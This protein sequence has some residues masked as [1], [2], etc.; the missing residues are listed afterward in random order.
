M[1]TAETIAQLYQAGISVVPVATDGTKRPAIAWKP[2]TLERADVDQ[3]D[4]WFMRDTQHGVGMIT[5]AVSGGVEM[6]ELEGRA[7]HHLPELAQLAEASGLADLWQ[8]I[9]TGWLELSPSGGV[10]WFYRLDGMA[11]PGNTKLAAA[12]D[13]T[14]LAETRGE[15]GFVVLAPTG[16]TA[17]PTGKPWARLA[18]GPT[19]IPTLT[20][21]ERD[22]LHALVRTLDET[23]DPVAPAPAGPVADLWKTYRHQDGD[24]TPGDD[25]EQRTDWAEILTP[26]GWTLIHQRGQ[27][28]YWCRPGKKHGISASTGKASDRDRL[29]VFT[30]STEFDPETPYTKFGAYALL[31]HRGDHT[32]AAKQLAADG[33]GHRAPRVLTPARH[34]TAVPNPDNHSAEATGTDT[35]TPAAAGSALVGSD[36]SALTDAGNARL[37]AAEYSARLRFIPDAGR[38]A[39][40]TGTRWEWAPDDAPALQAALDIADRLPTDY[41]QIRKHRI[42]S[43]GTRQLTNV[44]RLARALPELRTPAAEFDT[45]PWQLNTPDGVVDLTTGAIT[46]A[47]PHLYHSKQTTIAPA[48]QAT[49]L[50]DRF[51]QTTFGDDQPMIT[52]V[53]RLAGLSLAG[54]VVEHVLP[55]LH[56]AGGNGK[57]VFLETITTLL[58][59]YA[60]EAPHGFLLAGRD[61][62]ETELASLQGRR[63]VVAAEINEG[64]RFDEAKVKALTGG[65]KI[66][67]RFMRQD[68]FTFNPSHTLWLMGNNQPKVESGG[69][70]FWRRLRLIPFTRIIPETERIENLQQRLVD[71][72]G[73]GILAWLI[74]GC[75][76]YV[77]SGL[78][79]PASVRAAT[80][81]YQQEEDHLA[82]FVEDRCLLGGGEHARVATSELRRVYDQWCR[83]ENEHELSGQSFGRQLRQKF[84]IDVVRSNGRRYYTGVMLTTPDDPADEET[85]GRLF[86]THWSDR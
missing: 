80:A 67:A 1:H 57:T 33:Y 70:S 51:L 78:T 45:H 66:T 14:T 49:P 43:L 48:A 38:W 53:Q 30:S 41:E 32:A 72:E 37:L 71:E 11:V 18:G 35:P 12:P 27:L 21:A 29:Y 26:H 50:W 82:R 4:A 5:G 22:T 47:T 81:T 64:T 73:P 16:G 60:T 63:F 36:P 24:I 39:E 42:K 52:Y 68:F 79:E 55:F 85:E 2:Y 19:T 77:K 61:R 65:D 40:W 44:V 62:H 10:H 84:D 3:L 17:H 9:N 54:Q 23:P 34:L 76:D 46:P 8:R 31:E 13:K 59:D 56:G 20:A 83:D 7:A 58:G 75:V 15:G 25:Y 69:N 28:R 86:G 74:Q 6:L